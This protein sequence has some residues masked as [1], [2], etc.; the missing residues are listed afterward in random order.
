[1]RFYL[2]LVILSIALGRY[3]QTPEFGWMVLG[4]GLVISEATKYM[5][6]YLES[7]GDQ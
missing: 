3:T 2:G 5:L 7:R 6:E 1:M 4:V